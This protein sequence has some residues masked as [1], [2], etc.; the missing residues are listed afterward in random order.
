QQIGGD[1]GARIEGGP[2]PLHIDDG[3]LLPGGV[4]EP[5]QLGDPALQGHLPALE[6]QLWVVPR[7]PALGAPAGGLALPG[8]AAS[9]HAPARLLRPL[10]RLQVVELHSVTSSTRTR[11]ETLR[12]MPRI[13]GRSS[14]TTE[15]CIR[16]RPS[17][18][19]VAFWSQGRSI[20]LRV[21]V[22][23]SLV[24]TAALLE[25]E[26]GAAGRAGGDGR[27]HGLD[28]RPG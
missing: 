24:A 12:I 15:S 13:S 3:V 11:W 26:L 7:T 23:R 22:M 19:M 1:L 16:C 9:P 25:A 5:L 4:A 27:L 28:H 6:P 8:R 2:E 14:L 20:P 18:R 10:R 21:C 17:A